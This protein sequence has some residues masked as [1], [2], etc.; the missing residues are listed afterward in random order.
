MSIVDTNYYWFQ[1]A[2]TDEQCNSIIERGLSDMTLTEQKAGKKATDATTFDFRQKGGEVSNAGNVAANNLT[3]EGRRRKGIKDEDIYVRDTKVGWLADKWIYEL[4]HPFIHE[5]NQK[6][7]WNFEWDFSE[8]CQFTVYHPGM[9]Y[10]WHTDGGTRPYIPFDPTVKE[11]RRKDEKGEYVIVKNEEGKELEFDETY[12]DG[13]FKGVKRYVPAPG[14]VDNPNQ[15]WKTRKLSVTVNLTNPKHYKGGDLKF[16]LGPHAGGK[17]Y[18][19]C[20]EIRPRGSII[21]FPSFIH[22][23]VT[24]VTQGTRYSLVIWNLGKMFK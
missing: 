24:P 11:Q 5:A 9:F 23:Q 7:N 20:K 4:I 14:F 10:A 6:A 13:K 12:R 2:L 8:T 22:H 19:L 21:V 16:D 18:H 15:F 1:S 17:R 3:T